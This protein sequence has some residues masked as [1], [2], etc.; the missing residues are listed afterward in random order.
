MPKDPPSDPSTEH[1]IF[2]ALYKQRHTPL[3]TRLTG[4]VRDRQRAEDLAA[5]A[6]QNAWQRRAQFRGE[7]SLGTWLYAIGLNAARRDWQERSG[8][9]TPLDRVAEKRYAEPDQL[10]AG[11]ERE[12]LRDLLAKTLHRIPAKCRRLLIERYVHGRS[13]QELARHENVPI[14]TIGSRLFAAVRL[15]REAWRTTAPIKPPMAEDKARQ[16]TE[17]ALKHLTEELQA[18]RSDALKNYLAAMGR[19]HHYSWANSLLIHAQRPTATRV[20]GYH[21]WKELGRSVR[22]GEKGIMIYAPVIRKVADREERSAPE[23]TPTRT[24]RAVAGFRSA[25]VFDLDQTDGKPLPSFARTGG[26]P[27]AFADRLKA[28]IAQRGIRLAYDPAIAPADG[29]SSGGQIRLRPGLAPAEE[30]SVLTHELAHEMLHHGPEA[31]QL[32][33]LVRETQAEA[34]AYVVCRGIGLETGTA[35]ADYIALYNG[36]AKTLV[37]SLKAIQETA[38]K[39]LNDL[40]PEHDRQVSQRATDQVPDRVQTPAA[41]PDLP[42]Q[43]SLDR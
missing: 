21:A 27:S 38:S 9:H 6:F 26:D 4:L 43:L 39:I 20:A 37:D 7:S 30:F 2:A 40:L 33:K 23:Q 25:Y 28:S 22:R 32:S 12:E 15:F 29:L 19:F 16:L 31:P 35:A 42:D 11:L 5:T 13:I 41:A 10:S 24:P 3:V 8:R 18:G 14:G 34:V 17:D 36:D 1:Q